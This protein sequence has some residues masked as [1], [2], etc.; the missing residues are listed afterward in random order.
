MKPFLTLLLDS[1]RSLKS[2]TIFWVTV[3]LSLL[4]AVI[5]LSIGYD[6]RGMSIFFG[7]KTWE[8][9]TM[10]KGS[11]GAYRNYLGIFSNLVAGIWLT[12]IAIILALIS[13][14]S[15]FPDSMK[16]GSAGML[17]TKSPSRLQVFL[18][19]LTGSLFFVLIQVGL[20]VVIVFLAFRWR[21]GVWN[22]SLFWYVPAVILV[23]LNLYSFMVLIGVKTRSVMTAIM[24]TMLVWGGSAALSWAIGLVGIGYQASQYDFATEESTVLDQTAVVEES[25][26]S[27]GEVEGET[28]DLFSE[29]AE[30]GT[31]VFKKVEGDESLKGWIDT[32]KLIHSFF[33][34]NAP[35]MAAAERQL[36][37]DEIGG[38]GDSERLIMS[39]RPGNQRNAAMEELME[40]AIAEDSLFYSIGTSC[41]FAFVML[42]LA[43]W[44][45]CRKDL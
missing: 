38:G 23:F 14:A 9:D 3:G 43:G 12:F 27:S 17:M 16:E 35:I 22:F 4:V 32:L 36:V 42:S 44:S 6:D 30:F 28:G 18:A 2:E 24:L 37:M 13:C 25:E 45:F 7:A 26:A 39:G 10:T 20:F 21:L 33:P 31:P 11:P 19:K 29:D 5:F 40:D 15:I 34:K 41:I 8:D 1:Y